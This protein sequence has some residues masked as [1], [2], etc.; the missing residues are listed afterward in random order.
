MNIEL[1]NRLYEYRKQ[2][3]LSQEELAEKLGIS[4]Q[5]VS[6][7]ERAESCPDTDNL[8]ELAKIYN[9]SLD[10][11]VNLNANKEEV[12][13][14]KEKEVPY[15]IKINHEIDDIED[16]L[17][18]NIILKDDGMHIHYE[19]AKSGITI[20]SKGINI[21]V[22]ENE[23]NV[24]P[25][26]CLYTEIKGEEKRIVDI[27]GFGKNKKIPSEKLIRAKDIINGVLFLIISALYVS[28][29]AL[30]ITE[31]SKFWVIFV[32][33]PAVTS[34]LES[35]VHKGA[36]KFTSPVLCA[37]VY[38]TIGMYFKGWH[39]YWFIFFIVPIYHTIASAFKK[40][41]VVYYYDETNNKHFFTINDGDIQVT[42]KNK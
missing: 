25:Y 29:C 3:G 8:I 42:L 28:L 19:E 33:Y 27:D 4:R 13:E 31:W 16:S 36:N 22:G 21:E 10:T 9:V 35:I 17:G 32:Y 24:L 15:I 30:E 14:N 26:D 39:P 2:S 11:L 41:I 38:V 37:A 1:A 7:W 6:K 5:S 40:K 34:L 12:Q 20:N 18:N 23:K